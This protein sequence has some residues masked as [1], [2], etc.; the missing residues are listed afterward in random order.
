ML[1]PISSDFE[2]E[3]SLYHD[4][5]SG[6]SSDV[7]V[8]TIFRNLSMNIISTSHLKDEDEEMIQSDTDTWLKH[9]KAPWDIRFEQD[10]PPTEDK[11]VQINLGS[12]ANLKPIFIS[13]NLSP[14]ENEDLIHLIQKYMNVLA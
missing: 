6:T 1:T 2:S 14:S 8:G 4:H 10:E 11:V 3:E 5:S 9:L 13:K 12:E 7:S